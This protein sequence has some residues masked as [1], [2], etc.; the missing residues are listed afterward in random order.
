MQNGIVTEQ[1]WSD[2]VTVDPTPL[3]SSGSKR[4]ASRLRNKRQ[5]EEHSMERT[6]VSDDSNYNSYS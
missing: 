4:S 6:S 3:T 2:R 5:L 1:R